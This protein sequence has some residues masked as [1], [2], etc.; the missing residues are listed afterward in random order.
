MSAT[1]VKTFV[2]KIDI[3][4]TTISLRCWDEELAGMLRAWCGEFRSRRHA[5]FWLEIELCEGLTVDEVQQVVY[6]MIRRSP[7][8]Q[9]F[10]SYPPVLESKLSLSEHWLKAKADRNLFHSAVQ[11][12]FLNVLLSS[13]YSTVCASQN[14]LRSKDFLFHGCGVEVDGRGYLFTGPS[15]AGKSTVAK[16]AAERTVLNDEGILLRLSGNKL[17]MGG[18]PLLGG[19]NRRSARWVPV[20]A[21][22]VLEHG[23][24]V[25]LC[26]LDTGEAFRCFLCQLF[27]PTPLA[28]GLVEQK[29]MLEKQVDFSARVLEW[30]P[31]YTLCFRPDGSFW[32]AVEAL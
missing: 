24:E 32:P 14:G 11:P 18:T 4:D 8:G 25:K 15:G 5:D 28:P 29:N 16:L 2:L 1:L 9:F 3:G 6:Q 30:V 7:H 21:I 22:L 17:W 13:V 31:I 10:G 23:P 26:R 19:V 20:Q 12:R 27:A